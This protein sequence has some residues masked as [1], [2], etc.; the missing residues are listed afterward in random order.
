MSTIKSEDVQ[1]EDI[2]MY[3]GDIK[4]RE[5]FAK[6]ARC[7]VMFQDIDYEYCGKATIFSLKAV[8]VLV[9]L[10]VLFVT[11]VRTELLWFDGVDEFL[12]YI[13]L[14]LP[15]I[16][17]GSIFVIWIVGALIFGAR[18]QMKKFK[19]LRENGFDGEEQVV[20][21]I[22]HVGKMLDGSAVKLSQ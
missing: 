22:S 20:D 7:L 10:M 18:K 13:V 12:I 9:I 6:A 5:S 2:L 17:L 16:F 3:L 21:V 8:A 14:H 4:K 15:N 1:S 11:S 19:I